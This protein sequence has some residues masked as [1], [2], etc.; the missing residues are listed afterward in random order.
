MKNKM[1]WGY[2]HSNNT[3]QVKPWFGD[4]LDYTTD[5]YNNPF[6][7]KVVEPFEVDTRDEALKIISDKLKGS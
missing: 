3:I 1:W 5:C 2:L 6:V 7:I 4:I